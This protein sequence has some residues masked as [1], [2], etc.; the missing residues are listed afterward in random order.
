MITTGRHFTNP[1][2]PRL[3]DRALDRITAGRQRLSVFGLGGLGGGSKPCCCSHAFICPCPPPYAPTATFTHSVLGSATLTTVGPGPGYQGT[4]TYA[5]PGSVGGSTCAPVSMTI[6]VFFDSG[7]AAGC[8]LIIE[9]GAS[10]FPLMC[11]QASG[12]TSGFNTGS[13]PPGFTLISKTASC[14]PGV[15]IVWS[16][17]GAPA[18]SSA[19]N[20]WGLAPFTISI[21]P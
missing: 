17:S 7:L 11:P 10:S 3:R 18:G 12:T 21:T 5:Y 13:L 1:P 6:T 14:V 16:F 8:A 4:F 20:L 15:N 19:G 9:W 2:P